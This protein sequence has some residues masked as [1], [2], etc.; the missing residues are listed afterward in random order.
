MNLSSSILKQSI[1]SSRDTKMI[2]IL[3]SQPTIKIRM[4]RLAWLYIYTCDK[5][6]VRSV[7]STTV[8]IMTFQLSLLKF[9]LEQL[10]FVL[11]VHLT[12]IRLVVHACFIF[13]LAFKNMHVIFFYNK[14]GMHLMCDNCNI[15]LCP[16]I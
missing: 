4:F 9:S 1:V 6:F 3:V 2:I 16:N 14:L 15:T 12:L 10:S 5:C 8:I 7:F 11:D 13:H